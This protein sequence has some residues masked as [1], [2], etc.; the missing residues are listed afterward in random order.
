M[1]KFVFVFLLLVACHGN[2]PTPADAGPFFFG[3]NGATVSWTPTSLG[4]TLK[5]WFNPA[6]LSLNNGD[7]VSTWSDSSGN[8]C[9]ATQSGATRPTYNTSAVNSRSGVTG[10]GSQYF[11][12]AS[13][14]VITGDCTAFVAINRSTGNSGFLF[15]SSGGYIGHYSDNKFYFAND[16][17]SAVSVS[18]T[19]NGNAILEMKRSSSVVSIR[20]SKGGSWTT[21]GTRSGNATPSFLFHTGFGGLTATA[22]FGDV[23]LCDT[24]LG[25]TD[26]DSTWDYLKT[27]YGL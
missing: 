17:G 11:N 19:L 23:L 3:Q 24:V 14:P 10:S 6:T 27:K 12:V 15:G 20:T 2:G 21:V 5:F 9:T 4:S 1:K 25:I 13:A 7:P 22:S 16:S 18:F 8:S 26:D